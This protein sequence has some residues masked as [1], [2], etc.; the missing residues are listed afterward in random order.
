MVMKR[1]IFDCVLSVEVKKKGVFQIFIW[2]IGFWLYIFL[3]F[4]LGFGD[5]LVRG[6][7]FGERNY[8]QK[9]QVYLDF[10]R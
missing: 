9:V 6:L 10:I 5:C 8:V 1:G 4:F 3:L 2:N 7:V